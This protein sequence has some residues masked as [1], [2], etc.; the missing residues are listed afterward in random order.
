M[1]LPH[2]LPHDWYPAPLP[3][4]VR[5]GEGS[6]LYSSFAFLHCRS[7]RQQAVRIGRSSGVYM[8]SFFDL[9]PNGEVQIGDFSTL[10]GVIICS[11][12]KVI[13]GDYVF[14]AHEVVLADHFAA[15]PTSI[16]S[17]SEDADSESSI[18]DAGIV[19][20]ENAWIGA[21][22]II[23]SGARI[24]TGA[25]VGA[26]TVVDFAVPDYAVVT[27]NPGR[28]MPRLATTVKESL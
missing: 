5:I 9:G 17:N 7:T 27:G 22:A 20:G 19:I 24:G 14:I 25:I 16:E 11:D 28:F 13:I 6:W 23:L 15:A 4:N 2:S 12:Q 10:V 21:G 1:T 8:G 18:K 26:A 3:S